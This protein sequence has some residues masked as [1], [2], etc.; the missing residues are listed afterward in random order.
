MKRT[1]ALILY[2]LVLLG[3]I[4]LLVYAALT[5]QQD[6]SF[7]LKGA[8]VTLLVGASFIATL[9]G[10]AAPRRTGNRNRQYKEQYGEFIGQAFALDPKAEKQLYKA[11]DCYVR[12]KPADALPI[13]KQL[14]DR[15]QQADDRFA[16]VTFAA[17]SLH[18]MHLYDKAAAQYAYALQLRSHSTLASNMGLCFE[19]MGDAARAMDAYQLA[20]Q[21]DPENAYAHNNMAVLLI[22]Q[23]DYE[24]ALLAAEQAVKINHRMSQ[25]LNS[26]AICHY[27]LGNREEYQRYYRLAVS[28]GSDGERLKAFIASLDP[29]L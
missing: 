9:T 5:R 18:D 21:I 1:I 7:W 8:S 25:A 15:C 23:G 6:I 28:A 29:E 16:V 26:M 22:R 27:M 3:C 2:G 19:R 12:D 20:A 14:Y 13:L 4:G 10:Q 17:L 24:E 11:I